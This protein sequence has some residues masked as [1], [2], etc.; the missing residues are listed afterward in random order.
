MRR[1]EFLISSYGVAVLWAS[2]ALP[3]TA[4]RVP[5]ILW[6]STESQPDPFVEGFREGLRRHGYVDG[7]NV[8]IELH[9]APGNP[10]A[11]QRVIGELLESKPDLVVASGPAIRASRLA[12]GVPVLFVMSGDPVELGI[13]QSLSRP[14]GNFTGMTFMSLDVAGKRIELLKEL[15]PQLAR[16]AVLSNTDHPGEA[17][18]WRVS[19]QV[20]KGL[21]IEPVYVPFK[22]G[23]EIDSALTAIRQAR[24]DAV[25]VFP[26]G[27][28]MVHRGKITGFV[29]A[30]RLPS[31]FG[32][33]EYC[34][35]GGLMSYGA[36]QRTTYFR[37][38]EFADR[39][40]RGTKP[41][42]LPIEQPT[43]FELVIN[44]KTAKGMDF[45]IPR[46]LLARA[47][48]VIE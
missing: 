34:D 23:G 1:R 12:K 6:L 29:M 7:Q 3:Q 9:Y 38:A 16:L 41:A 11:L 45:A 22:G 21:G 25:L 17:S 30:L 13:A 10:D 28:T 4:G 14:G 15:I 24:A 46:P 8:A 31:M 47:D 37:L 42:E 2:P 18:E 48:E 19:Q 20:A 36:N 32:W 39:L 40:L 5:R 33:R 44:G 26:E 35:A 27:V 43:I